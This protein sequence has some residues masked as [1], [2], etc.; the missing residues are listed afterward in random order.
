MVGCFVVAWSWVFILDGIDKWTRDH[1][2]LATLSKSEPV[3]EFL[4]AFVVPGA[5]GVGRR[6][7]KG[8]FGKIVLAAVAEAGTSRGERAFDLIKSV[9][10]V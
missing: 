4:G 3:G 6:R 1:H 7:A 9:A 8:L 2:F 10:A 5:V